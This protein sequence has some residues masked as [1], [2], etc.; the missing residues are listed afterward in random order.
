MGLMVGEI[1]ALLTADKS[2]LSSTVKAAKSEINSFTSGVGKNKPKLDADTKPLTAS[3]GR[4]KKAVTDFAASTSSGNS[5]LGKMK[6]FLGEAMEGAG[7]F[8]G[9][10]GGAGLILELKEA[11]S[12]G[13]EFTDALNS[14]QAAGNATASQM[15]N[16]R[17]AAIAM[18]KDLSLP[19]ATATDAA[20]AMDELTKAG[21]SVNRAITA[22]RPALLLGAAANV[23]L[24]DAARVTGDVMDDFSLSAAQIP[25]VADALAVASNSAGGGLMS[26]FDAIKYVGP[27]AR[28]AGIDMDSTTAAI[29]ELAKS[30][31][32]G[33]MA[34]TSLRS[35][36]SSLAAP[37]AVASS[38]LSDL[39]VQAYNAAGQFVGLPALFDQLHAAQERLNPQQFGKDVVQA[40]G[41]EA[42]SAVNTFAKEGSAGF[43]QFYDKIHNSEGA[44]QRFADQMNQGLGASLRQLQKETSAVALD[45]YNGIAPALTMV[46]HAASAALGVL[47]S[48]ASVAG[49]AGRA[50]AGLPMPIQ[51]GVLA[52]IAWK[53]AQDK[54]TSG[55]SGAW[56][57][58]VDGA[59]TAATGVG[60][61]ALELG[62]S[63]DKARTGLASF[64]ASERALG[65]TTGPVTSAL[66][67]AL[68]VFSGLSS[69]AGTAARALGS[70][71]KSA[72]SGLVGILGGPWG[73]AISAGTAILGLFISKSQEAAKREADLAAAGADVAQ[74]MRQQGGAFNEASRAA[75]AHDLEQSGLLKTAQQLGIS[76]PTVTSAAMNQGTAYNDLR[77]KL[78]AMVT[79]GTSWQEIQT[80][81]ITTNQQVMTSQAKTAKQFL[82]DL[83][84]FTAGRNADNESSARQA[85]ASKDSA[86]AIGGVGDA[87]AGSTTKLTPLAAAL[88]GFKAGADGADDAAKGF[89]ATLLAIGG[90]TLSYEDAV[91][92]VN[93]SLRDLKAGF[94]AA[95]AGAKSS[96]SALLDS[97]G[98]INTA[99][100]AGSKL[101]TALEGLRTAQAAMLTATLKN[102]DANGNATPAALAKAAQSMIDIRSKFAAAAAAAGLNAAQVKNLTDH[103]LGVPQSVLTQIEQP[104]MAD[105]LLDAIGLKKRI[106]EVPGSKYI[107]VSS[108]SP[109]QIALLESL[110]FKI[111]KL[112]NGHFEIT[113][114]TTAAQQKID[115]FISTN[116]GRSIRIGVTVG[117]GAGG[118]FGNNRDRVPNAAGRIMKFYAGGGIEPMQ[119]GR[120]AIVRSFARTGVTR[121][122]GDNP[123]ASES[124]IPL[125]PGSDRSQAILDETL[126]VMRPDLLAQRSPTAVPVPVSVGASAGAAGGQRPIQIVINHA[127][128][129]STPE[130]IQMALRDYELHH[131][132]L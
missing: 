45:L 122:I 95:E 130:E 24:G 28:A 104:G 107:L 80:N 127:P 31:I 99:T 98:G 42:L 97:A 92:Q 1:R 89:Q 108:T 54:I 20:E 16:A 37:T 100:E 84:K 51:T 93:D 17:S 72:V 6:G 66:R 4:G 39:G 9:V 116:S 78:Q 119:S 96:K 50:F 65:A 3:L 73:L 60:V 10:L 64:M 36:L 25:H 68:P 43:D 5:A 110:G 13:N 40:F 121:V 118:G 32:Q 14:L 57:K 21:V 48:L 62:G 19:G 128:T 111:K 11:F 132:N 2:Q 105:A 38:A 82:D 112:P 120:A 46:T 75:A 58:I 27:V 29:T 15:Q 79:A 49:Q 77:T 8:A 117:P 106:T 61:A 34:G 125:V 74:A 85:A 123:V 7:K 12:A 35:M 76:L 126:K 55:A 86:D 87:A 114:N 67:S 23:S 44:A 129:T 47:G 41:Q 115:G 33:S 113:A 63:Y 70:G 81:G 52:L 22:S 83:A 56:Q 69:A 131:G 91:Q 101:H 26:L 90:E 124:Y 71:L 88:A 109:Q 94:K 59:K 102:V 103:Y 18:G 30:G 53:V